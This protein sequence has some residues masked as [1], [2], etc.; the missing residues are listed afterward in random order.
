MSIDFSPSWL[1]EAGSLG[2]FTEDDAVSLKLHS[3]YL[4]YAPVSA[5]DTLVTVGPRAAD[6][7]EVRDGS[8]IVATLVDG[9][10]LVFAP[11]TR[12]GLLVLTIPGDHG[13][14]LLNGALPAGLGLS[15]TGEI[16]GTIGDSP[17]TLTT[18][19]FTVRCTSGTQVRDRVFSLDVTGIEHP[20]NFDQTRL[21]DPVGDDVLQGVYRPLGT[22]NLAQ[23]YTHTFSVVD[24]DN[25]LPPI[26]LRPVTGLPSNAGLFGRLP[27]GLTLQDQSITGTVAADTPPGRYVFIIAL[28]DPKVPQEETFEIIIA[29]NVGDDVVVV[30]KIVWITPS[31]SLG[32]LDEHTESYLAVRAI[33]E[34]LADPSLTLSPTSSP[35]PPGLSLDAATG[36][37]SGVLGYVGKSATY[38]FTVRATSGPMYVDRDF[39]I[40]VVARY[41][42]PATIDVRL[43]LRSVERLATAVAYRERIPA[44]IVYRAGD[45]N[46]GLLRDPSVYLISGLDGAALQREEPLAV[47]SSS[48]H[49]TFPLV[50]GAHRV[51]T[52]RDASGAAVYEVLYRD[53]YDPQ[54]LAGGF[55]ATSIAPLREP[56]KDPQ[57]PTYTLYPQSVRN[58]RLDLVDRIGFSTRD[59]SVSKMP[60]LDG[61]ETLPLWMRSEQTVGDPTSRLGYVPALV[62]GYLRVGSA[63]GVLRLIAKYASEF[64]VEGT[65]YVFD[66]LWLSNGRALQLEW[67]ANIAVQ[68]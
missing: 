53:L 58:L 55:A 57:R 27:N 38:T 36:R 5:G 54:A 59:A 63:T 37:I 52:A 9:E 65:V 3:T 64:P 41:A 30:P 25:V 67:D 39:S 16:S 26:R 15:E 49:G 7:A 6:V 28:D 11:R 61:G 29:P 35:L 17:N 32:A 1:T 45:P 43:R 40:A 66:K 44:A 4:G 21:P 56:F 14:S 22:L 18:Y 12:A 47:S 23:P 62:L 24:K 42:A 19:S 8:E 20:A 60:G 46:F 13:Y 2:S 51:A 31:G 48:Y 50:L 68:N 33:T 10:N 34:G